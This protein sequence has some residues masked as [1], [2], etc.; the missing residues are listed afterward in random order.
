METIQ[1][2]LFYIADPMCS[3]C[4]GFSPVMGEL[5][6]AYAR[7]VRMNLVLG[8]LRVGG[9]QPMSDELKETVLHHWHEVADATG[10]PFKNDFDVPE[11]F[12]YN[13]EPACRAAVT[14]RR[15]APDK[16]FSFFS[17]LHR[18]FYA[19]NR[20]VTDTD[21]LADLAAEAGVERD[22][23]VET[24][25]ADDTQAET[26]QDFAFAQSVGVTGF[27][28]IVLKDG[29]GMALLN[30]GYQPLEQL[31]PKLAMWFATGETFRKSE[32]EDDRGAKASGENT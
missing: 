13:T 26:M 7:R 11:G 25:E 6:R 29:R 3:W 12:I 5:H 15:L 27:P 23:F 18:A 31:E 1:P 9:T 17:D 19:E 16:A 10:Q 22:A 8:G 20:D 32:Q 24:F 14:V 4:W 21:V 30:Y 28:S 2:E